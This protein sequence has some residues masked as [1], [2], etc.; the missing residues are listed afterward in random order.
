M[1]IVAFCQMPGADVDIGKFNKIQLEDG[2]LV[3]E[4]F[5]KLPENHVYEMEQGPPE[6]LW[7]RSK[8][9]PRHLNMSC[10][11]HLSKSI[12]GDTTSISFAHEYIK[13]HNPKLPYQQPLALFYSKL[14]TNAEW[15]EFRHYVLDSIGRKTI[16]EEFPDDILTPVYSDDLSQSTNGGKGWNLDWNKKFRSWD[17][18]YS[19]L[20][21]DMYYPESE[22]FYT[23]KQFDERKIEFEY[24][25]TDSID[26]GSEPNWE[27]YIHEKVSLFRDSMAWIKDTSFKH[28]G[29]VEDGLVNFY[30]YHPYFQEKPVVGINASQ[31]KAFL[32]WKEESHNRKLRQ[33]G[34]PLRVKYSLRRD[35][36]RKLDDATAPLVVE[37]FLLS[38]WAVANRDYEEFV[39]YVRDSIARRTLSEEFP[40]VFLI[41]NYDDN[42]E[43]KD[44]SE[45][46]LNWKTKIPWKKRI[47]WPERKEEEYYGET[48]KMMILLDDFF[49][50]PTKGDNSLIE[51]R[52]LNYQQ[53]FYNFKS[54]SLEG[55]R[56]PD[57]IY[58]YDRGLIKGQVGLPIDMNYRSSLDSCNWPV[59][60][61]L[62]LSFINSNQQST[63]VHAHEDRS[64][65]IVYDLMNIY[66]S[67]N[68]RNHSKICI[69]NCQMSGEQMPKNLE[70]LCENVDCKLCPQI[71]DWD[72]MPKEYDFQIEP[73]A[74]IMSLTYYQFQ[75][76]WWWKMRKGEFP[77]KHENPIIEN[78][79][80]SK[81]EFAEIQTGVKVV[82]PA[83]THS[84]PT[85]GFRCEIIYYAK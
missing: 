57:S 35:G 67:I 71:Y 8:F 36:S 64:A 76:Y 77:V 56:I 66:P 47:P 73:K 2:Y 33:K 55:V 68:H 20:L 15:K 10:V 27:N 19:P 58:G 40:D 62:S 52:H 14:V 83:E 11:Y 84:L 63:D 43:E 81:K 1:P 29:N 24:G 32:S 26:E 85:P 80:P 18:D 3:D 54:A 79:M 13:P 60:K 9:A 42:L 48:A 75:A 65:Y 59:G 21:A 53:W 4:L 25:W 51:K 41:P 49:Q 82:H 34:V 38:G 31:A 44:Q 69:K 30:N 46:K 50:D 74:L 16:S 6:S 78:Y 37:S 22:R 12:L 61:G 23:R 72:F 45:W 28:F 17:P 7:S 5:R 70:E 39:H